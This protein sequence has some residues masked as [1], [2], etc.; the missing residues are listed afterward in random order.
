MTD[1]LPLLLTRCVSCGRQSVASPA[2]RLRKLAGHGKYASSLVF[3]CQHCGDVA[4]TGAIL[5][6]HQVQMLGIPLHHFP[7]VDGFPPGYGILTRYQV[8]KRKARRWQRKQK[9]PSPER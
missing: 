1:D 2:V 7:V 4:H 9:S 8:R 5:V 6:G 3:I